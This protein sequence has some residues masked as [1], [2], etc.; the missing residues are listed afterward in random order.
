MKEIIKQTL[1]K[2][3]HPEIAKTLFE[4]G[5]IKD[6]K[7]EDRKVSLNLMLPLKEISIKE[8]LIEDI[9]R[10]LKEKIPDITVEINLKKM[11]Q[12]ERLK[13]IK[14]AQEAW[15]GAWRG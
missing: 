8:L 10:T 5:M 3:E 15:R 12:E 7:F 6:I 9:K 4:L 1:K 2:I 11:D 14:M 13:F